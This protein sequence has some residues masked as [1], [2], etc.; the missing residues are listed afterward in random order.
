MIFRLGELFCGPGGIGWGAINASIN[1]PNYRII[2]QWANDYDESTCKTYRYNICPNAPETVYHADIRTFDMSQLAPIDAL[3]F[4]FPCNDYS[5]VGEQKGMDGTF[6]SL[7]TYGVKALKKFKPM[8]F[9]AEN[10]GGLKSANNGH[11]FTKILEELH[12]VGYTVTPHL[13]KFEDYGIPQT[14]HRIIIVGIRNDISVK[15]NV[16]SPA[17]FTHLNNTCRN[18]IENPPIPQDAFNNEFTKQSDQVVRRLNYIKPGQNAFTA[19]LPEDLRL[20]VKGAKISQIYKRLDPNK[21]SYTVTG[22]GGGG[23]HIYHWAEP[24]A[25]TNRERAR[26]QTFPDTYKFIGTKENVR[27]Q[28]GMAVPCNGAKIIFEAI[29]NCFAGIT[30][31]SIESNIN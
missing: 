3:A 9:L 24:R 30:Y 8:W 10:V 15:F 28:I 25:L 11:A 27:K 20:N 5:V 29:L 23:T 19:E 26:L 4:G 22:S 12:T 1:N 31:N 14:R 7:Y 6:G 13:Y 2:H 21:P 16:P 17:P 18:A